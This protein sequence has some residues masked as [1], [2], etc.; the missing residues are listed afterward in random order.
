MTKRALFTALV[1]SLALAGGSVHADRGT[2]EA[3]YKK[4]MAAYALED[5]DGAIAE[6]QAG[7][8]D[9]PTPAFLYNIAQS[10]RQARRS[11]EAVRFYQK[12]LELAPEAPD[13]ADVEKLIVQLRKALAEQEAQRTA[14]PPALDHK[15]ADGAAVAPG[16]TPAPAEPPRRDK[17][18]TGLLIGGLVG[19]VAG[20]SLVVLGFITA[21]QARDPANSTDLQG[22]QDLQGRANL[23]EGVGYA[24]VGLGAAV[25]VAGIIKMAIKPKKESVSVG[26]GVGPSGLALTLG[27]QF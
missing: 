8:R 1:V 19:A 5:W 26:A 4:G 14:P 7:F 25:A 12:Y 21:K 18:G 9:E 23:L 15:P 2:A 10:H 11:E 13:R 6:F 27:G 20:G 16:P 22:R 3:H 24:V 17:L